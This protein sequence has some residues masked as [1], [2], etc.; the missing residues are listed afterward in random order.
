MNYVLKR[1]GRAVFTVWAVIT[2]T[3]G[4]IR[5]LPGGPMQ[6]LRGYLMQQNPSI[7]PA[8]LQAR[9]EALT[10][11]SPDE[12]IWVQYGNYLWGLLQGDLGQSV[13]L[14]E[15]VSMVLAERAP[16][17]LFIMTTGLFLM[18]VIGIG[19]GAFM[20]YRE[21]SKFD[22]T[23]TGVG[24]LLQS[25]PFYVVGLVLIAFVGYQWELLPTGGHYAS[26]VTPGLNLEFVISSIKHATL[27]VGSL[28]LTGFGG[29]ALNMRGNSIRILGED[30][31]RV[32]RLRGLSEG[33]IAL[34]Y[35]GRNALLPM[36]TLLLISI[37][38]MFGGSV[39]LEEIFA[40]P[41]LGRK[42]IQSIGRRDFPVMMGAFLLITIAVVIGVFIAD[43]TY[44]LIDPRA[45]GG[46]E[47]ES[48]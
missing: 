27:P 15:P 7:S 37:G 32:A 22:I 36:Y 12:P 8:E 21:G 14:N 39:I 23:T 44:G 3:F 5:L 16:W 10:A 28:V 24:I 25:V 1:T 20:A 9:I 46:A 4:L 29:W 38:Y 2:L 31:L 19:L 18:F 13:W 40:Y 41:G 43:L 34:R 26:G 11:I 48:Y 17:T 6:A 47:R 42:L 30:Y 33:R 45:S 35:V